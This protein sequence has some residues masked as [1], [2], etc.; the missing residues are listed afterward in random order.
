MTAD[1]RPRL[2]AALLR[3]N[4]ALLAHLEPGLPESRVR[5]VLGRHHVG[6]SL[7]PLVDVY[8]WRNGTRLTAEVVAGPGFFPRLRYH[9]LD[10]ELALAH[11][12]HARA[13]AK[14]HPELREGVGRYF[15]LFWN[16]DTGWLATDLD[17]SSRNRVLTVEHGSDPPFRE[18]YPSFVAFVDDVIGSIEIGQ[19][20]ARLK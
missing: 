2:E 13:A 7:A 6:G 18:A 3:Q 19:P 17:A 11:F 9:L 10:L 16:G 15:P 4:P 8:M 1:W 20:Q 12:D 14:S 5:R